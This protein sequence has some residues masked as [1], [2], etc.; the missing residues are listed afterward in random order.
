[1]HTAP[2]PACDIKFKIRNPER[3]TVAELVQTVIEVSGKRLDVRHVPGPVGVHARN[4][5]KARIKS[6]GWEARVSLREGIART[7]PWIAAQVKALRVDR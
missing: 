6:L 3:V 5:S 4:F 1:M 7:Y 2:A